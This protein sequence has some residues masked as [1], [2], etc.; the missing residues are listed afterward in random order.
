MAKRATKSERGEF[1][2][3]E[4][5]ASPAALAKAKQLAAE[6][7]NAQSRVERLQAEE[8][9]LKG[10]INHLKTIAIPD[11]MKQAGIGSFAND[12]LSVIVEDF[13]AGTL[14][15]EE[16]ARQKALDLIE[17]YGGGG[18]IRTVITIDFAKED[19][20]KAVK[21]YKELRKNNALNI[22]LKSD[23]HNQ[24]YLAFIRERLEGGKKI[25]TK[26]LNV[27]VGNTTKFKPVKK[28]KK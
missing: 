2:V 12:D 20:D 15:K 1:E 7:I 9:L 22:E 8:G 5:D 11:A 18:L 17:K 25:D 6:C 23:I 16:K 21:L 19:H 3:G 26:T 28:G 24:T 13:V 27:F 4:A 10:R 14:P